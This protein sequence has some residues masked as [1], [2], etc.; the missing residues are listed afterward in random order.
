MQ[1]T[2]AA[3]NTA[4][5]PAPAPM[6]AFAPMPRAGLGVAS[7][8]LRVKSSVLMMLVWAPLLLEVAD[9]GMRGKAGVV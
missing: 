8:Y 6:P 7:S 1:S 2:R 3:R 9:G 5:A 4:P